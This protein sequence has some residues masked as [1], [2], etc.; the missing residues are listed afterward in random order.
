MQLHIKLP[1]V[2]ALS[3]A[4]AFSVSGQ[5]TDGDDA[6]HELESFLVL[7][8]KFTRSWE[9][10]LASV[11]LFGGRGLHDRAA[12][13][14]ESAFGLMPNVRD[15]DFLDSGFIIR[16]INSEGIGGP[17]GSPMATLYIDGVPQTQNGL[18]RGA[19]ALWDL[20]QVEVLRGPQSVLSGRNALAGAIRLETH[21]PEF[22]TRAAAR[23]S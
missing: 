16:G 3:A 11:S 7:G 5:S 13:D 4:I 21:D 23:R 1:A 22:A 20:K 14:L 17:A 12:Q 8:E 9:D 15:A 10:T 19:L 6:V 18:R 2:A